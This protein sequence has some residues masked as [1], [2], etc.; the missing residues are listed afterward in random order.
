M[1]RTHHLS[2]RNTVGWYC[3][4]HQLTE[5]S[6]PDA[7]ATLEHL[8]TSDIA[9]LKIGKNK[10]ALMLNEKGG[11]ID[12]VII[13]RQDKDKFWISNLNLFLV[14]GTL[15]KVVASGAKIQFAPITSQYVMYAVQGP[16]SRE[17]LNS[18]TENPVD[19]LKFFTME[20]N[21]IDGMPVKI[22]RAGFTGEAFGYEIYINPAQEEALLQ[23]LRSCG[24]AVGAVEVTELQMMCWTL[25]CE[26]GFLLMRDLLDLT[27]MD[28]DMERFLNWNKDFIGKEALLPLRDK[29]PDW[30]IVGFTL[31][32]DDAFIPSRHYGGSGAPVFVNGDN[33]GQV[34]KFVYSFVLEKNIGLLLIERGRVQKGEHVTIRYIRDYDAIV[35]ERSFI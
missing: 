18:M 1:K 25:P 9:S 26:K 20:D 10:Y 33:I 16:K 14:Y 8:Y 35:T 19:N 30:E 4:T 21:V 11:I 32:E 12:D 2:V 6:G 29:T 13:I 22:N 34:A 28:A 7:L 17:L 5:I 23:K 27:P 31:D 24:E 3:F 15:S